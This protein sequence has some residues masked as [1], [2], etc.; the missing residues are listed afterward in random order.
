MKKNKFFGMIVPKKY[1][2]LG[3]SANG[4]SKVCNQCLFMNS[5]EVFISP[6]LF[7]LTLYHSLHTNTLTLT[8]PL[9]LSRTPRW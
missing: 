8:L 3:F 2:G 9:P 4:H 5:C 1:G 7:V 6:I